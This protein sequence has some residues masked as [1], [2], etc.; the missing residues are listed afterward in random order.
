MKAQTQ[1]QAAELVRK[2]RNIYMTTPVNHMG[3]SEIENALN[4]VGADV[5]VDNHRSYMRWFG[6]VVEMTYVI[7]GFEVVCFIYTLTDDKDNGGAISKRGSMFLVED[8]LRHIENFLTIQNYDNN[9]RIVNNMRDMYYAT[10]EDEDGEPNL[11][12]LIDFMRAQGFKVETDYSVMTYYTEFGYAF[13]H[14]F[15]IGDSCVP[16]FRF[17]MENMANEYSAEVIILVG[18]ELD[19]FCEFMMDAIKSREEQDAAELDLDWDLLDME[20]DSLIAHGHDL[21]NGYQIV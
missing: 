9:V 17:V 10:K 14:E 11:G 21:D 12:E 18:K 3:F 15:L 1:N 5:L 20:L 8:E 4:H 6:H 16:V 13:K 2:I 19:N 7:D